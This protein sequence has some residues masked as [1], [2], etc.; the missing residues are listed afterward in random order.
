MVRGLGRAQNGFNDYLRRR[1]GNA[2]RRAATAESTGRQRTGKARRANPHNTLPGLPLTAR[3]GA[4]PGRCGQAIAA[5]QRHWAPSGTGRCWV[6][7]PHRSSRGLRWAW[8]A[9]LSLTQATSHP[10]EWPS[11]ENKLIYNQ[12]ME[13]P[14]CDDSKVNHA[15]YY[16]ASNHV[17]SKN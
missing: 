4:H 7:P 10:D 11:C 3:S 12:E 9:G 13:A 6:F 8:R 1:P 5:P 15:L 16:Y 17:D 2:G 14:N